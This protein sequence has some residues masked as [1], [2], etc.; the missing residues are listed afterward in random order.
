MIKRATQQVMLILMNKIRNKTEISSTHYA[1][2]DVYPQRAQ[3][4]F[5]VVHKRP[6][7]QLSPAKAVGHLKA[8]PGAKFFYSIA[9]N[10]L[11]FLFLGSSQNNQHLNRVYC[12]LKHQIM[13]THVH[14]K[15][16]LDFN[17]TAFCLWKQYYMT[18]SKTVKSF[19][20]KRL[21]PHFHFSGSLSNVNNFHNT[22]FHWNLAYWLSN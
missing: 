12:T 20:I 21:L 10:Q 4:L 1:C 16:S 5:N 14:V 13:W 11:K 18:Y 6:L 3:Q 17:L 8:F 9:T 2:I 22:C 7:P 19:Y 15:F